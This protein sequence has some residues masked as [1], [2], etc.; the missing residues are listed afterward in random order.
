MQ[1]KNRDKP[2]EIL[3]KYLDDCVRTK[4]A[5]KTSKVK[6]TPMEKHR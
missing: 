4:I 3:M 2:F 1:K 5:P 6:N